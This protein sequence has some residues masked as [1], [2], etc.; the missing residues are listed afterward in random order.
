MTTM[1]DFNARL[2]AP[3]LR[4]TGF[5]FS[6]EYRWGVSRFHRAVFAMVNTIRAN[7]RADNQYIR[8]NHKVPP[9]R[10]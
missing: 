5:R 10:S 1:R 3:I 2:I 7:I 4:L 9:A 6:K 8:I